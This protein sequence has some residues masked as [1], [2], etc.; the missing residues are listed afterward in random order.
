MERT[1]PTDAAAAGT[2]PH[3]PASITVQ[4][5]EEAADVIAKWRSDLPEIPPA[6]VVTNPIGAAAPRPGLEWAPAPS[7][8]QRGSLGAKA[9]DVAKRVVSVRELVQAAVD[10]VEAL[11]ESLR[12]MT[13]FAPD[14]ALDEAA[15]SDRRLAAGEP[16]RPLEGIT[17]TFKDNID[18]AGMPTTGSSAAYYVHPTDDSWVAARLRALGAVPIGKTALHEFALGFSTPE[19]RNPHNVKH[20]P[21]GSS[22]GAAVAVASGMGLLAIGTDTRASIRNPAAL[23]GVCGIKPSIHRVP[24][25]GTIPLSWTMDHVGP[26]ARSPIDAALA[27]FLL[28]PHS[29]EVV[30]PRQQPLV[31]GVPADALINA[32]DATIAGF[33]AGLDVFRTMGAEIREVARPTMRDIELGQAA[34]LIISR[35]EASTFHHAWG[36]DRTLCWEETRDQLDAA[37]R[38]AAVDFINASRLREALR[39]EMAAVLA[40]VS[41]LAMPTSPIVAPPFGTGRQQLLV[42]SQN[43][44]LWSLLGLPA[45][46]LPC[47]VTD[48]LPVGLQLILPMDSDS[49][50]LGLCAAYG[51]E[52]GEPAVPR[53]E[54]IEDRL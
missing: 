36:T 40:G 43:T 4:L 34:G 9:S 17:V 29:E 51:L 8:L 20:M 23:C 44:I 19:A 15:E 18:V 14:L 47:P 32:D 7:M 33:N 39:R 10:R 42:L 45:A 46:T 49:E 27:G 22:G 13:C 52:A 6:F 28:D 3:H 26:L 38:I 37:D 21:G 53:M 16:A 12:A 50:M 54:S 35:C 25:I 2:R 31:I 1:Q 30:D 24:T 48:T 41:A 5:F 11:E